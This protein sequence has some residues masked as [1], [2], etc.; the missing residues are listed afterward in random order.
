MGTK[1]IQYV[2]LYA[3]YQ[4]GKRW[5]KELKGERREEEARERREEEVRERR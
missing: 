2:I 3:C 1:R 4:F 5:K